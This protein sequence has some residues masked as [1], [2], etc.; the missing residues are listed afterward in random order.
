MCIR[1]RRRRARSSSS[2]SR[3]IR[4]AAAAARGRECAGESR[5]VGAWLVWLSA[6]IV[7]RG[8]QRKS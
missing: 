8:G 5:G 3:P 7:S 6:G 2:R 1:D 4:G